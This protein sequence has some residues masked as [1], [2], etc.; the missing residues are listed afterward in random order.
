MGSE[1]GC[2]QSR[3]RKLSTEEEQREEKGWHVKP[4][5]R[6]GEVDVAGIF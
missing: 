4:V 3:G 1:K 6:K 2:L 5:E